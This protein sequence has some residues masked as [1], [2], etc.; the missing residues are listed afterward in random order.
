MAG[1]VRVWVEVRGVRQVQR[2]L[3]RAHADIRAR[4]AKAVQQSA[5]EVLAG[6]RSRVPVRTG[7][8]RSTLRVEASAKNPFYWNVRAGF[9]SHPR[10]QSGRSKSWKGGGRRRARAVPIGAADTRS[11]IYAAVVE[12]GARSGRAKQPAQPYLFPALEAARAGHLERM[13]RVLKEACDAAGRT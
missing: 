7:E 4:V 2:A 10:R 9:G 1:R 6:A 13:K 3:E 8:L 5:Q 12:F 11:G